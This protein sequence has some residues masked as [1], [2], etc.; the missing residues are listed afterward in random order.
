MATIKH[1]DT[2]VCDLCGKELSASMSITV[3]VKWTTE[4]NEGRSCKPYIV[5]DALDLCDECLER[6]TAIEASGC[7][8]HS[9]FRLINKAVE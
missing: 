9:K 1:P 7:M 4:Q 8:G 3:P 5:A 2:Y 6:V